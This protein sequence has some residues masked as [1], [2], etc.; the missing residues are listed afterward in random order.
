MLQTDESS[1]LASAESSSNFAA[2]AII[3]DGE[4][5]LSLPQVPPTPA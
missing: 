2:S 1:Q 3:H 5:C 4:P